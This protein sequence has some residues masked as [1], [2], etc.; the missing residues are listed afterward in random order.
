MIEV[1]LHPQRVRTFNRVA[2]AAVDFS[3]KGVHACSP[4]KISDDLRL[5][6]CSRAKSHLC[7]PE[8]LEN[9]ACWSQESGPYATAPRRQAAPDDAGPQALRIALSGSIV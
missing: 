7:G 4:S 6:T 8:G 5:P 2:A 1:T 9:S 3:T